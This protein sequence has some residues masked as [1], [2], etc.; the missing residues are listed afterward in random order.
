M[1][2][3]MNLMQM[4]VWAAR[5]KIVG[6]NKF[7]AQFPQCCL[8]GP[9]TGYFNRS[10][11]GLKFDNSNSLSHPLKMKS[12]KYHKKYHKK[13]QKTSPQSLRMK[14]SCL[15]T[16]LERRD[17]HKRI[18]LN[19]GG[20]WRLHHTHKPYKMVHWDAIPWWGNLQEVLGTQR[21]LS[22]PSSTCIYFTRLRNSPDSQILCQNILQIA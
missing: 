9:H 12:H 5:W 21:L 17:G 8:L 15:G 4:I 16:Q 2:N 19:P 10:P 11:R 20:D 18:Y 6:L 14:V 1:L 13:H 3:A 22:L 7:T